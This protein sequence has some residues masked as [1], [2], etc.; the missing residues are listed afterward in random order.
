MPGRGKGRGPDRWASGW[1]PSRPLPVD[2]GLVARSQ[3]GGIGERWWSQRFV[4][5]LE[6]YGLGAR[7]SRGRRYARTGQVRSMSVVPGRIEAVVQGSRP[8]PYRCVVEVPVFDDATWERLEE[9]L[10]ARAAFAARLLDG[11]LPP[12][13]EDVVAAETGV[14]LLPRSWGELRASCSC[15]DWESPCKH[16]AATLY[17]LA[18]RLDDDPF[19][20][21]LLRGRG[22]VELL[23]GLRQRR[24]T[25]GPGPGGGATPELVVAR[26]APWWP[27]G[28]TLP[29]DGVAGEADPDA[30]YRA[31]PSLDD[32]RTSPGPPAAAPVRMAPLE[33]RAWGR[34]V[35]EVLAAAYERLAGEG[36]GPQG[37]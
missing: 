13:L 12:D 5:V 30:W 11:E 20:V 36:T 7:M 26:P 17:L 2:G 10:A 21:L 34:P 23:A 32:A 18:E 19:A 33:R 35:A 15:P 22:R 27:D 4:A 1:P 29:A 16:L 8:T 9:R 6:S 3:R 37:P 25:A 31:G 14:A 28:V 24:G